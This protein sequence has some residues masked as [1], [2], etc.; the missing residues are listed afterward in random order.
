V[1]WIIFGP[2][3]NEESDRHLAMM[4]ETWKPYRILARK[5]VGKLPFGR[6]GSLWE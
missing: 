6:P 5:P 1:Q 4:G 2:N 3:K